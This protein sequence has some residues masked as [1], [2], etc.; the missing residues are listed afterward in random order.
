[1]PLSSTPG[2]KTRPT[3]PPRRTDG[4]PIAAAARAEPAAASAAEPA[5]RSSRWVRWA[6]VGVAV[7]LAIG[8]AVALASP[9]GLGLFGGDQGGSGGQGS[10]AERAV[11]LNTDWVEVGLYC[12]L[13]DELVIEVSGRGWLD[14]TPESEIGPDGLTGGQNPEARVL[15]DA[16]TGSVI[17]RLATTPEIFPIGKGTTY[18][19]PGQGD[20]LLGINDTDLED[21]SGEFAAFVTLN[22]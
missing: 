22:Q 5:A 6:V 1:M 8:A 16:P 11:P 9:M 14:D 19:C 18:V 12:T 7:V 21:N 20:L 3:E 15:S 2:A 4:Q 13:G 17:G 10:T